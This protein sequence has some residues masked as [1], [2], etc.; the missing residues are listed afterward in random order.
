M[1]VLDRGA[2]DMADVH[3]MGERRDNKYTAGKGLGP[4]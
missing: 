2:M 3:R 1:L 4:E